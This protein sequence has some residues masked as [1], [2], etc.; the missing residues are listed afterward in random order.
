[1]GISVVLQV[2]CKRFRLPDVLLLCG[3]V[4]TSKKNDQYGAPLDEV[5]AI[6]R[7][8]VDPELVHA[9]SDRLEAARVAERQASYPDI[10]A[11]LGEASRR[12]VNQSAYSAV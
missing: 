9:S 7:T 12:D 5:D 10:D 3:L 1:L 8:M 4:T 11:S 6:A 2:A